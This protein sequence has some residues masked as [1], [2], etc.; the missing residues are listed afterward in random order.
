MAQPNGNVRLIDFGIARRFQPGAS[1]DTALLG[2][3]G[4]S[5]PEQFGRHQTDTRS[6]IY[7]LGATLHHL[8]TGHDPAASPFKFK[9]AREIN[10]AVPSALPDLIAHCVMLDT[11]TRPQDV[12]S[13]AMRL[14]GIRDEL[15]SGIPE[16][17]FY[18]FSPDG[19]NGVIAPGLP[20]R[21]GSSLR[22]CR[23]E[24]RNRR[25][26]R[27]VHVSFPQSWQKPK[28]K[29]GEPAAATYPRRFPRLPA[30]CLPRGPGTC[31]LAGPGQA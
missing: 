13:V 9:P 20:A 11:E 16:P 22:R 25:R 2:S 23:R 12:H 29:S 6:D 21:S 5:P 17:D 14:L 26:V 18:E 28:R 3:V 15:A 30:V 1:K 4:Y 24:G 19:A 31:R 10:P 27:P 7:A 8:L